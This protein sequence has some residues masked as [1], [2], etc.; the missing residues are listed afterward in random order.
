MAA[1]GHVRKSPVTKE[2]LLSLDTYR[3]FALSGG[4]GCAITHLLVVPL[5]VVKTRLQT[6]PG[7]YSGFADALTTIREEEGLGML[8][9]GSVATGGGYFS[10]GV[11]VYPGYE[12]FKRLFFEAAGAE[13]VLQARVP[14]VLLAGAVATFFT[15][16]AITPFEAV[17]IRMVE[18]PNYAE[19]FA[20]AVGRYLREGGVASLYDGLIPLMIRQILFGMVKFL[21]FDTCA[22]AI[23]AALP[24]GAADQ[25]AVSLFVSLLSG[26]IAGVASAIISQ[27]AD[28]VLSKVAQGE[29]S[30]NFV[31]KLPG[32]V[33]QLALLQRTAQSITREYGLAGLYL[34]LPSRCLWSGAIIAG[35]F[36][37]YDLFK[38]ALHLTANDL[39]TFY[40]AFGASA[41]FSALQGTMGTLCPTPLLR[42]C[43]CVRA[44]AHPHAVWRLHWRR[45]HGRYTHGDVR[46]FAY[47]CAPRLST[48]LVSKVWGREGGRRAHDE[49]MLS[50]CLCS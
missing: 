34:G 16:F 21:V 5:D 32:T 24:P 1:L 20:G 25:A 48:D 8:F 17:R 7:A 14:L 22:D 19:S 46:R 13:L 18:C 28:V 33:N 40:D 15:C 38:Q 35:Q 11:C 31:G 29:G 36:F 39:T 23:L 43:A 2:R 6:R 41:A 12:F 45:I 4:C 47:A 49:L 27:P 42:V 30:S 50:P 3:G 9:Q 44:R 10:Y 37:L 26:A